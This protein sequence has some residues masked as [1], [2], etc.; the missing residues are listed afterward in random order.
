MS[1]NEQEKPHGSFRH[2]AVALFTT[3]KCRL[4]RSAYN[5]YVN[6]ILELFSIINPV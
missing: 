4:S 2:G 6:W 3:A 5:A 1:R